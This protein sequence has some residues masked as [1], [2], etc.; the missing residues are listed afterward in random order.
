MA[1]DYHFE[2]P[3]HLHQT[4][5]ETSTITNHACSGKNWLSKKKPKWQNFAQSGHT[6]AYPKILKS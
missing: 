2:S 4:T 3:K 5:F 6:T 1:N